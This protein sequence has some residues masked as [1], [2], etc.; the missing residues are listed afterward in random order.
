MSSTDRPFYVLQA[1]PPRDFDDAEDLS[2]VRVPSPTYDYI[3]IAV[4]VCEGEIYRQ[5]AERV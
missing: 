1:V 2:T 3:T 4:T 5:A